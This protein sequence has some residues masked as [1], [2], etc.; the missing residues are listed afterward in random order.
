MKTNPPSWFHILEELLNTA[1]ACAC[2]KK[3]KIRLQT[4]AA[5]PVI[6]SD[7]PLGLEQ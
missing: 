2:N 5:Q 3:E 6:S 1:D 4:N 7:K